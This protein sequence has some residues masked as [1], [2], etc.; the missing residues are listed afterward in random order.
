MFQHR[1]GFAK[2]IGS[3]I[4]SKSIKQLEDN[5]TQILIHL[6]IAKLL[7]RYGR[8]TSFPFG[9]KSPSEVNKLSSYIAQAPIEAT[10]DQRCTYTVTDKSIQIFS[11]ELGNN[12]NKF[13]F[14]KHSLKSISTTVRSPHDKSFVVYISNLDISERRQNTGK[15]RRLFLFDFDEKSEAKRFFFAL[16]S[17]FNCQT[18]ERQTTNVM[19]T[20]HFAS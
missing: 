1:H 6:A 7:A 5:E 8:S 12:N 11:T 16:S 10:N 3:V 2:Y 9:E 17:A 4:I 15:N 19:P 14:L 13:P 20:E 18:K